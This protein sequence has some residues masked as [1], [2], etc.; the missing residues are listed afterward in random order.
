MYSLEKTGNRRAPTEHRGV[1]APRRL[2]VLVADDSRLLAEALM[3]SLD[4]EPKLEA[5]GY[6]LD[7]W[8]ALEYMLTLEP[9]VVLVGPRLTGLSPHRFC[10]FA[11]E[12]FPSVLLIMLCE[13]LVPEAVESAYAAGVA[14]CLP[15][16]RSVD[17]LL[18]SIAAA[19]MRRQTFE[20]GRRRAALT[21]ALSLV[22]SGGV[23][24][25]P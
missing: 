15:L 9:D 1:E 8:E 18:R 24:A 2:R 23:D 10:Q 13:R 16:E 7:G 11:H 5:I 4:T 22:P 12:L 19:Q 14:D 17:Q 3:F 20:R 6:A 21:P 25:R